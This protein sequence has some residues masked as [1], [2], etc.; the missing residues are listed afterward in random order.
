MHRRGEYRVLTD[1]LRAKTLEHV[2][3]LLPSPEQGP[4]DGDIREQRENQDHHAHDRPA[5]VLSPIR[6]GQ[7]TIRREQP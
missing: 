5:G 7:V 6:N 1:V 4:G 3:L 2:R